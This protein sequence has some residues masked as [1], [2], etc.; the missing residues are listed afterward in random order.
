M[1]KLVRKIKYKG[2]CDKCN[3]PLEFLTTHQCCPM[4]PEV[5]KEDLTKL[6]DHAEFVSAEATR[7]ATTAAFLLGKLNDRLQDGELPDVWARGLPE[8]RLRPQGGPQG[9]T[10]V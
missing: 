6:K 1:K 10:D 3:T 7:L 2:H 5:T 9:T 4:C 8:D